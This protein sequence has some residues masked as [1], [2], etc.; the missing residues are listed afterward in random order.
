MIV[1]LAHKGRLEGMQFTG[2]NMSDLEGFR[3]DTLA[4]IKIDEGDWLIHDT[5]IDSWFVCSDETKSLAYHEVNTNPIEGMIRGFN[6]EQFQTGSIGR[7]EFADNGLATMVESVTTA[8]A[9]FD[10]VATTTD[11]IIINERNLKIDEEE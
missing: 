10:L 7:W 11:G 4:G 5:Q 9:F 6:V 1:K 8:P 2:H 3:G